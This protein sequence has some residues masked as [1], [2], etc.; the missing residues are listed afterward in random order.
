[1]CTLNPFV[2]PLMGF[3]GLVCCSKAAHCHSQSVM[4][5]HLLHQCNNSSA[6]CTTK[7]HALSPCRAYVR[8]KSALLSNMDSGQQPRQLRDKVDSLYCHSDGIAALS[9]AHH[10]LCIPGGLCCMLRRSTSDYREEAGLNRS[11]SVEAISNQTM[12][13][14][15]ISRL[16]ASCRPG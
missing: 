3:L 10:L 6:M 4:D 15:G 8:Y 11:I 13:A 14:N 1:M 5:Y 9:G 2:Q 12:T 7:K 16:T